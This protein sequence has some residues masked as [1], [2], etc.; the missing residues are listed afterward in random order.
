[1]AKILLGFMGA[2][3]STIASLLGCDY[4]DMDE[5]LA[6]KIG[7]PIADFFAEKGEKAF[8][9]LETEILKQLIKTD[10]IISTGGGVVASLENRALLA[11]NKDNIYLQA[12]F[13]TLYNRI[14]TDKE[15]QRPLFLSN[16]KKELQALFEQRSTWYEEVATQIINVVGRS[17]QEIIKDI[18]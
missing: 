9:T 14:K 13:E 8:R 7:M 11:T 2:G 12:D 4:V 3:K 18:R 15:N 5:L 16:N 6:D 10:K 17:P 1:M